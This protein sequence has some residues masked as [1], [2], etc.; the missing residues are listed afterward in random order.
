LW[1]RM[2]AHQMVCHLADSFRM[3]LGERPT[4]LLFNPV[5]RAVSR[6]AALHTP[7]RFPRGAP[8]M[9]VLNQESGGTAPVDF[10]QDVADLLAQLD[11][12]KAAGND[13]TGHPHPLFG[14]LTAREWRLWAAKHTD[15]H[16]RQFRV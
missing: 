16:L 2:T 1:G 4:R 7:M 11:R 9:N 12:F 3:A 5:V 10:D 13:L 14:K 8:T 15:H 6:W